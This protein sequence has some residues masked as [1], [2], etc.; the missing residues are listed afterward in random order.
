MM[1]N[2]LLVAVIAGIIA[3]FTGGLVVSVFADREAYDKFIST[4]L[5]EMSSYTLLQ[6]MT[7]NDTD[8]IIVDAR[9]IDSYNLGHIKGAIS[10]TISDVTNSEKLALLPRNKDM[11]F[12][13]W[14]EECMLGPTILA[15]LA[16][17]GFTNMKEL[18]IGWC[19]W[20]GRGYPIDGQRYIVKGECLVPQTNLGNETIIV[21]NETSLTCTAGGSC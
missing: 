17:K 8:F 5:T 9:D 11:I 18:R 7:N 16:Q 1:K 19:E 14:S 3:G 20:A 10:F 4:P 15:Q 2:I 13:C 6:K 12:Y 21:L